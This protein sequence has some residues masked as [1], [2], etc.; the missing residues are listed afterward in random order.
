LPAPLIT[1]AEAR[2]ATETNR[3]VTGFTVAAHPQRVLVIDDNVDA[4]DIL[5]EYL[6][7]D[8]HEVMVV[9]DPIAALEALEALRPSVAI[10]DIGMPVMDGYDLAERMRQTEPGRQCRYIAVTGYGQEHDRARSRTAGFSSHLVKP[11]DLEELSRI[12]DRV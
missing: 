8:G 12:V 5:G 6:R 9:N 1:A 4:A 2:A 10:V 11:V 7:E 3:P